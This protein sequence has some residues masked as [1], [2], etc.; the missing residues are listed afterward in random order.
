[1]PRITITLPKVTHEKLQ[2]HA[3]DNDVSL[4][5]TIAK[6][7]EIGL[8]VAERRETNKNPESQFSEIEKYCFKLIIQMNGLLKNIAQ[9]QLDYGS[10]EFKKL[11]DVSLDRYNQLVH[12]YPDGL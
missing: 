8:I 6:M 11:A 9:S 5:Q 10:D 2:K 1:M 12:V 7:A 4:S 3:E